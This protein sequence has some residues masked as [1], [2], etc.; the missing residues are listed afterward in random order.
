MMMVDERLG[1]SRAH[2]EVMESFARVAGVFLEDWHAG[3]LTAQE[4]CENR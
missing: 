1:E 2:A 4:V 3:R